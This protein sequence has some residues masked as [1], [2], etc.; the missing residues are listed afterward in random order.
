MK[1]ALPII[2]IITVF[3]FL[4]VNCS[5][6]NDTHDKYL[7]QGER[8]FIGKVDSVQVFPGKERVMLRYWVQDPRTKSVGFYWTP[9]SDSLIM[10][11]NDPTSDD[12][13]EVI[14]GGNTETKTIQEG[15]YTLK[16]ITYDDFGNSSVPYERIMRVYGEKYKSILT[17]RPLN[18]F[19][20]SEDILSLFFSGPLN[21]QDNGI[22]I[23]F[24]DTIG[25]INKVQLLNDEI[26]SPVILSD[27]DV[28]EEVSYRTIYL[29]DPVSIDTFYT[30]YVPVNL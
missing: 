28:N 17:N 12:F 3:A 1:N 8:I 29:P 20:Y 22:D 13:S 14:I 9:F 26:T 25:V 10:D 23:L 30:D 5:K 24:T 27:V 7:A 16:V 4:F 15:N 18:S 21:A 19:N 2:V 6:M 11:V